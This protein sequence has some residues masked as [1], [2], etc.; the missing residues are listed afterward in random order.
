[1]AVGIA[2][3]LRYTIAG[4]G[5][6]PGY[7]SHPGTPFLFAMVA[8]GGVAGVSRGILCGLAG[9]ATM[10]LVFGSMYLIGAHGRGRDS[11]VRRKSTA[12]RS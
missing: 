7:G 4:C 9:A 11:A 12:A 2:R 5:T 3:A 6:L 1:M 10:L 8:M